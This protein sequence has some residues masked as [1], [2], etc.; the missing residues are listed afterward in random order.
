MLAAAALAEIDVTVET[1]TTVECICD[2]LL[3]GAGVIVIAQEALSPSAQSCLSQALSEQPPWSDIPLIVLTSASTAAAARNRVDVSLPF[4]NCTLVE[5]PVRR[6]VLLSA[7]QTALRARRRQYEVR[8]HLRDRERHERELR[9]AAARE[10]QLR[11]EAQSARDRL[12][13]VLLGITD[14]VFIV[15]REW[16]HTYVNAAAACA[17]EITVDEL[18]GHSLWEI[19][20][21]LRAPTTAAVLYRAMNERTAEQFDWLSRRT[22]RWFHWRVYP[23]P[24]GLAVFSAD[25]TDRKTAEHIARQYLE[26]Q[27]II[28]E[29]L[30]RTLL[31]PPRSYPRL[32]IASQY[33]AAYSEAKVGGD[34]YDE[35]L[36]DDGAVALVVGDVVGK[37]LAAATHTAEVKY[38]LRAML[39]ED[40]R[41]GTAMERLNNFLVEAQRLDDNM[42]DQL[43]ALTLA[44]LDLHSGTFTAAVASAEPPLIVTPTGEVT[45]LHARGLVLGASA[46]AEYIA[47]EAELAPGDAIVMVTDGITE[48]RQGKEFFGL[49]GVES[50]I[51]RNASRAATLE[52]LGAAIIA[53][54]KD[55]AGDTLKDDACILLAR[56]R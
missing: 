6:T 19:Y 22:G 30:Q 49:E 54:A 41:A 5:R 52:D 28:A 10:Q 27:E 17:H 56:R 8:D 53:E 26:R 36:I 11:V 24:E 25:A 37:G 20:P 34:F 15:D 1:C 39:R 2:G 38:A 55:F 51:R 47:V 48:A 13:L 12:E 21:E 45:A 35:F 4:V 29:T 40:A 33:E 7:I 32:E 14:G 50:A 18:L 42:H 23:A 31:S 3:A 9:E 43:V 44:I 46:K 16:R